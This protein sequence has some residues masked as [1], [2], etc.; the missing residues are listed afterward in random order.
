MNTISGKNKYITFV[1]SLQPVINLNIWIDAHRARQMF[2]PTAQTQA[3]IDSEL[4][5]GL[6]A[7]PPNARVTR[8]K[9]M[10]RCLTQNDPR[11]CAHQ[12]ALIKLAA[13]ALCEEPA[14][15]GFQN[16]GD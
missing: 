3:M 14:I 7:Q 15:G 4:F 9:N 6:S 1:Q 12:T 10:G 8:V 11:K 2:K 16:G 13:L 5:Q